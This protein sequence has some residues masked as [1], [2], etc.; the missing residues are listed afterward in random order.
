MK[1][2]VNRKSLLSE[3]EKD[4]FSVMISY[5]RRLSKAKESK[6]KPVKT[7]SSIIQHAR[8]TAFKEVEASQCEVCGKS[9]G[10]MHRHHH[11]YLKYKD[12]I[13]LCSSCH[14]KI[15]SFDPIGW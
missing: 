14:R 3:E 4:V 15:H 10:K 1:R 2:L 11:N 6:Y 13:I 9:D 7:H 12:V 8:M 5:D